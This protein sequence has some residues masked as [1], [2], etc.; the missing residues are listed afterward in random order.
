MPAAASQA[1]SEVLDAHEK[2]LI[3]QV[4]AKHRDS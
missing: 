1:V 3:D 2:L 4:V